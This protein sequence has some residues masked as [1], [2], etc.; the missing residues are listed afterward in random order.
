[1][2]LHNSAMRV[3]LSLSVLVIIAEDCHSPLEKYRRWAASL[4]RRR[5]RIGLQTLTLTALV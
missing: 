4:I 3:G 5:L 2:Y 1:M